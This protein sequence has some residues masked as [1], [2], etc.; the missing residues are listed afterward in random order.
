[1]R[2]SARGLA[3][4]ATLFLAA[5]GGVE[6]GPPV[7]VTIPPATGLSA[8]ADSLAA[9]GIIGSTAA[10]KLYARFKGG[11]RGIKPGVYEIRPGTGYGD[12]L[13]KL[14]RGDV[15]KVRVVVPEGW[16]LQEI[17]PRIAAATGADTAA[18]RAAL[19]DTAADSRHEVP[20]PTLEGYL[21]PA[22]YSFPLG[23]GTEAV[24][25]SMVRR[26]REA[27]TPAMRARADSL[28][29]TEREI[30][31]LASIVEKEAKVW[32]ERPRISAVYHNRL[33]KGMRLEADPTVQYA[34]GEHT[35]RLL[36]AHIDEVADNPYNTYRHRGLPPG[37]IASPSQGALK[38]AL[39]PAE[40]DAIFFVA[41]PNGTHVF[42]RTLAEHNAAKRAV[43]A[44][45][46]GAAAPARR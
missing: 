18:V 21:Y 11:E 30:V 8:A 35:G 34:R 28:G 45:A 36:Y 14:V 20:G 2:R 15:V 27:W 23:T 46:R 13:R 43:R 26:Y 7:R 38:A 42:T 29:M 10:F 5:C 25:R 22:T 37:P 17:A 1:M 24:I 4:M 40:D 3:A 39:W 32:T 6:D 16:T 33:K 44:E 31:A 12:V 9:R 19:Q 41:R